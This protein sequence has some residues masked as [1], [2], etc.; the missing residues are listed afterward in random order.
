MLAGINEKTKNENYVKKQW[1]CDYWQPPKITLEI[2][3]CIDLVAR[4]SA[5]TINSKKEQTKKR[6]QQKIKKKLSNLTHKPLIQSEKMENPGLAEY[7]QENVTNVATKNY[8]KTNLKKKDFQEGCSLP[9]ND[10]R[11]LNRGSKLSVWKD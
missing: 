8:A 4:K 9:Y 5:R 10:G 1:R 7:E 11:E 2:R 3:A 6:I